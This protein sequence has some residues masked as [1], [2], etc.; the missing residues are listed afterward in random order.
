M[1]DTDR[2]SPH[3]PREYYGKHKPINRGISRNYLNSTLDIVTGTKI[4]N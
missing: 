3:G 1:T 2:Q 4:Y